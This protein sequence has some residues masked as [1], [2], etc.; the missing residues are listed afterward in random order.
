MDNLHIG[1][2]VTIFL[3]LLVVFISS[4]AAAKARLSSA[5]AGHWTAGTTFMSDAGLSKCMLFV[6][7]EDK[8]GEIAAYLLMVDDA[9]AIVFNGP[10]YIKLGPRNASAN[11]LALA[12]ADICTFAAAEIE[13]AD[14]HKELPDL[15]TPGP[16]GIVV[17]LKT[18]HMQIT[19]NDDSEEAEP[20]LLF[21]AFKDFETS[22]LFTPI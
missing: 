19:N 7:S 6:G 18:M 15:W 2:I 10:V 17:N 3:I 20:I 8:G 21:S 9:G 14:D 11:A 13:P 12:N 5:L 22:E 16:L 4:K 1:L